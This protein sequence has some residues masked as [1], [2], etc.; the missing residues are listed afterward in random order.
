VRRSLRIL[1]LYYACLGFYAVVTY[2]PHAPN[3]GEYLRLGAWWYVG[4]AGNFLNFIQ[5]HFPGWS[6]LTPL[7]SMQVEEQFYITYPF[8]AASV[9]RETLRK[10]LLG[11][12]AGAFL[13]RCALVLLMPGN[14]LGTYT[15]A[16]CRMDAVS[17]GCL[18]Q[19]AQRDNAAWLRS[20]LV[21][22]VTLACALATVAICLTAGG[23]PW[24]NTMRT[25]G[26]SVADVALAGV[27]VILLF[28][29]PP[30][31]VKLCQNR[32]LMKLGVMSY[33]IYLLHIPV[34]QIAKGLAPAFMHSQ[35]GGLAGSCL[36]VGAA[37]AAAWLSWTLFESPI[38]RLKRH[39]RS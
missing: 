29:R 24:S 26:Y 12:V 19:V 22:W 25:I 18:I 16:P 37:I 8:V 27:L 7:W 10:I 17:L 6:L 9:R 39:F 23:D 2:Y 35:S 31:F 4:Y 3:V 30:G 38:L 28:H 1:P 34:S 33:G 21:G 15:L 14:T 5:N 11:A 13:I 32:V 36:S 20:R